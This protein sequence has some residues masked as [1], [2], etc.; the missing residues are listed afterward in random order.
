MRAG[1]GPR[2][3]DDAAERPV[4]VVR[5][6]RVTYH[7]NQLAAA[8]EAAGLTQSAAAV[9]LGV[10]QQYYSRLEYP[11]IHTH[12]FTQS[13]YNFIDSLLNLSLP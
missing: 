9:S 3:A 4:R 10:S 6:Y 1:K 2:M 13:Q 11:R 5:E 12:R 8:R 7:G